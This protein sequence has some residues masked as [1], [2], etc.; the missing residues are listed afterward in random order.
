MSTSVVSQTTVDLRELPLAEI[1]VDDALYSRERS[2]YWTSQKYIE[3]YEED[4]SQL[5]PLDVFEHEGRYLLA[6]GYHRYRAAQQVELLTLPCRVFQGTAR[7]AFCH[8][9]KMNGRQ[10]GLPYQLGDYPRIIWWYLADAELSSLSHRAMARQIGCSHTLVDRVAQLVQAEHTV[11][12][13]LGVATVARYGEKLKPKETQRLATFLQVPAR[14]LRRSAPVWAKAKLV[15][16]VVRGATMEATKEAVRNFVVKGGGV[17][18]PPAPSSAPLPQYEPPPAPPPPSAATVALGT[19]LGEALRQHLGL[20]EERWVPPYAPDQVL[21]TLRTVLVAEASTLASGPEVM[22]SVALAV[23]RVQAALGEQIEAIM[24]WQAA[25]QDLQDP[26]SLR[27]I[28]ED[29]I[30]HRY[31]HPP[32][33]ARTVGQTIIA[34]EAYLAQHAPTSTAHPAQQEVEL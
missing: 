16:E 14:V 17:A 7:D 6:D 28:V 30:A 27:Q 23:D 18:A 22:T 24:Q 12:V 26:S 2:D 1:V 10:Q 9:V 8:A 25:L 13:A 5:P 31:E 19:H 32:A 33:M 34:L 20:R 21:T 4:P 3:L 15:R 29:L 11:G